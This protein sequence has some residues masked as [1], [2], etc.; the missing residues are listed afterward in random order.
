[1]LLFITFLK[2]Y[3]T[4]LFL[5]A[6]GSEVIGTSMIALGRN[7]DTGPV[8]ALATIQTIITIVVIVLS[9]RFLGVKL[10]E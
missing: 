5:F 10:Y 6:P 3:S 9:R 1:V 2:E 8:A 7:G 4:A